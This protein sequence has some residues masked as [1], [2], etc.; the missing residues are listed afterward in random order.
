MRSIFKIVENQKVYYDPSLDDEEQE[1]FEIGAAQMVSPDP[2]RPME[3][4]L[5]TLRISPYTYQGIFEFSV[6]SQLDKL[7]ND[8]WLG[9]GECG[10]LYPQGLL[11]AADI[12]ERAAEKIDDK[13][14]DVWCSTEISPGHIEY[15]MKLQPEEVRKG[16]RELAAF[17]RSASEK[18]CGVQLCL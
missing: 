18:G 15:R 6:I 8:G 14:R 17:C 13:V 4:N 12:L 1:D 7:P 3:E 9:Q 10:T 5:G 2:K 16:L 11:R